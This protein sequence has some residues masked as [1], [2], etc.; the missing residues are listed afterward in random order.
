MT[1]AFGRCMLTVLVSRGPMTPSHSAPPFALTALSGCYFILAVGSLSVV[2]LL[3]PMADG[4]AVSKSQI[5]YLV[6]AFALTYAVMAPVLQILVG[7]W[8]RKRLL[9]LGLGAIG[10][11]S[12][13]TALAPGYELGAVGRVVMAVGGAVAGPMASAAGASL[14][15]PEN[16]GAAL[17]KVF[18]GMTLATVLGVPLTAFAGTVIG[19]RAT[20]MVIAGVAGLV[21]LAVAAKVPAGGRGEKSDAS[22][23]MRTL[24]DPI[25]APAIAITLFQMAAQFVTYAVI[26]AFLADRFEIGE[27]LLPAALFT[28]GIGGI[29]GNLLATRL[30]D[31]LGPSKLIQVSLSVTM[32]I[33]IGLQFAP[34]NPIFVFVLMAAWSVFGMLL[35]APQQM[36]LISLKPERANLLLAL[37][38]SAIYLGMAGGAALSGVLYANSGSEWL[39][40]VSGG[41]VVFAMVAMAI[42]ERAHKKAKALRG[43]AE[44]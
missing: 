18:A 23:V 31:K 26:A 6:T 14:V 41:L 27:A 20:L 8:D 39:A 30:G 33:F 40:L 43:E 11:G 15:A 37:N 29:L 9:L 17:G 7:D 5:A 2:G 13:I 22:I 35:F 10:L 28:F 16:R 25:L 38:G 32:V 4:L 44:V 12:L 21:A 3:D 36:R 42:S 1:D 34:S 24:M 19:W